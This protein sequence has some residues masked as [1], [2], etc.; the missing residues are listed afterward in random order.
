MQKSKVTIVMFHDIK[1]NKFEKCVNY[2]SSRY[3][4]ISLETFINALY[5]KDETEIPERSLIITFDDGHKGNFQLLPQIKKYNIPVTI[6]LCSQIIDTKRH[7]WFKN[8]NITDKEA[9]KKIR[10]KERLEIMKRW[11]FDE[12]ENC[13]ERQALSLKEINEMRKYVDFQSHT[14]FHPCITKCSPKRSKDEI[15]GSKKDIESMIGKEITSIAYPNGDYSDEIIEICKENNYK[16]GITVDK[17]YNTIK[18]NPF[19]LKRFS[20]NDTGDVNELS[21]KVSG[22]W[23]LLK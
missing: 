6:F 3:N 4:I 14:R 12:S 2:L 1:P 17:G 22:L 23:K 16:S 7:Y 11:G 18:S 9:L 8:K 10:N 5:K 13:K 20:V 21:V 19:K 15:I